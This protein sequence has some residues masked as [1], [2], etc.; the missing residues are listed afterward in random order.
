[1]QLVI[2]A[3]EYCFAFGNQ[4]FLIDGAKHLVIDAAGA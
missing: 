3:G 1:M 2:K 4:T